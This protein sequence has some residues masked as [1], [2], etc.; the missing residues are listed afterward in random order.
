[1]RE[2][3]YRDKDTIERD[4]EGRRDKVLEIDIRE[5]ASKTET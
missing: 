4:R 2:R 3:Y 1:M 5:R